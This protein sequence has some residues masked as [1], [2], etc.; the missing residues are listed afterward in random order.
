L[1]GKGPAFDDRDF[2]APVDQSRAGPADAHQGID[3]GNRAGVFGELG[4]RG[5][6]GRH[7]GPRCGRIARPSGARTDRRAECL[8]GSGVGEHINILHESR[9]SVA[10]N[11]ALA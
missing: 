4:D 9:N 2:L 8:A 10:A 5:R 1:I 3:F 7:R 11:T 6:V